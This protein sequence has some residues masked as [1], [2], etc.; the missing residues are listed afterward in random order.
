MKCLPNNSQQLF[1]CSLGMPSAYFLLHMCCLAAT[2]SFSTIWTTN[3]RKFENGSLY[4]LILVLHLQLL[5]MFLILFST[6]IYWQ[7]NQIKFKIHCC[8]VLQYAQCCIKFTFSVFV[9]FESGDIL[10]AYKAGYMVQQ[11]MKQSQAVWNNFTW[12]IHHPVCFHKALGH[13]IHKYFF[14]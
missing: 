3:R 4:F 9:H 12:I 1:G 11:L 2:Q 8:A 13:S 5:H 7:E 14:W 10:L 6:A